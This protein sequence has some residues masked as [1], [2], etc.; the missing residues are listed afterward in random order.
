MRPRQRPNIERLL[1]EVV[2]AARSARA[3]GSVTRQIPALADVHPASFGIAIV[4]ADGQSYAA[5]EAD[6][7]FSIQSIS[8]VFALSLVLRRFGAALWDRVGREPSNASFNAI[9]PVERDE[10]VPRNPFVN[11]G[12]LI[13]TDLMLSGGNASSAIGGLLSPL[14]LHS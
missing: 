9:G 11:G 6:Q 4:T 12:A 3:R 7:P 14:R 10:G 5:G 8:K 2:A 13:V 1:T